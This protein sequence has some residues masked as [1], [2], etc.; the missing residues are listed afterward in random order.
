MCLFLC[1]S[2]KFRRGLLSYFGLLNDPLTLPIVASDSGAW[3][4]HWT[5]LVIS[6]ARCE[7]RIAHY[8]SR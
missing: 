5:H 2:A 7:L 3:S 4:G 6:R 1:L 8:I